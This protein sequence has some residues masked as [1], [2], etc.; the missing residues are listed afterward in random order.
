MASFAEE[1]KLFIRR[2]GIHSTKPTF[3]STISYNTYDT[4]EQLHEDLKVL[5][6]NYKTILNELNDYPL[7]K[8]KFELDVSKLFA[9]SNIVFDVP[10]IY[11]LVD[12][13]KIF[14]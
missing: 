11:E 3:K 6:T 12:R 8:Q 4:K 1:V 5:L 2:L 9:F 14:K 10:E 13:Q 7:W